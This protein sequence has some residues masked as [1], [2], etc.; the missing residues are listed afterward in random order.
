MM[1]KLYLLPLAALLMTA[2]SND[3]T[4]VRKAEPQKDAV[5]FRPLVQKATRGEAVT[6][7]N[8]TEFRVFAQN[9]DASNPALDADFTD[10]V[11]SAGDGATWS[12]E[13]V[14]Y[15]KT[16]DATTSYKNNVAKFTAVYPKDLMTAYA[17]TTDLDFSAIVNGR[18]LK[19]VMVAYN[20]GT[21]NAN[22]T[23][24]VGL[25]FKHVLSQIVIQAANK[26]ID[27][28]R[29]EVVGVKLAN[30]KSKN[31][32]AMPTVA[33]GSGSSYAPFAAAPTGATDVIIKRQGG[34]NVIL[35]PTAKNIMFDG[36]T[37]GFMVLPQTLSSSATLAAT[38]N[39]IS[40][41][42]RIYKKND[43]GAWELIYPN[44][45]AG[46]TD[47]GS[48]AFTS[49]GLTGKWEPGK[50]YIYTLNFYQASG[51]AGTVDPD[52]TD[53]DPQPGDVPVDDT[54]VPP[55]T[56]DPDPEPTKVPIFFTVTVEDW[57][58]ASG[59]FNKVMQ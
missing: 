8:L 36:S 13:D 56:T 26:N 6:L 52:P 7:A 55:G 38:D 16:D 11:T 1:K 42:C 19:D 20:T 43:A 5:T 17:A 51:G 34:S 31:T 25:N 37:G 50:K 46:E 54:P 24:G 4:S 14:H 44:V 33:T 58:E 59:D 12:T 32:L 39:Y 49:I 48:Y 3:E 21:S 45:A 15:W 9:A 23:T 30:L 47:D 35:D 28:R 22:A 57:E 2:C 40:V 18:E 53:P 29:I 10:V 27:E 41:L